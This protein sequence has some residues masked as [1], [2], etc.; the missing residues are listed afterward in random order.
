MCGSYEPGAGGLAVGV[1]DAGGLA[2]GISEA[3]G[4]ADDG[5]CVDG[6]TGAAH[7]S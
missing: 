6:A 1:A 3:G 2:V 5:D 7:A 4:T